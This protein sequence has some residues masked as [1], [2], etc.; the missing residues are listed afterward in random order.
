MHGCTCSFDR[1]EALDSH[2]EKF[3]DDVHRE[4]AQ[5]E[6]AKSAYANL[7]PANLDPANLDPAILGPATAKQSI[8][9][10]LQKAQRFATVTKEFVCPCSYTTQEA[11]EKHH[12]EFSEALHKKQAD[13]GLVESKGAGSKPGTTS[14]LLRVQK[15]ALSRGPKV[16]NK[17]FVC[18]W[19]GC[20]FF[21]AQQTL[22]S[23]HQA[24]YSESPRRGV[25]HREAA[26]SPLFS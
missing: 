22:L 6:Q 9:E 14:Q 4:V 26:D 11:L 15:L 18:S 3:D 8:L 24:T 20:P 10:N 7:D 23:N 19:H 25:A 2:Q 17:K 1:Q 21:A 13:L 5:I 12:V 16:K